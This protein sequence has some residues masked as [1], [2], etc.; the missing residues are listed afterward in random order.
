M[1]IDRKV[2]VLTAARTSLR[3][4][5]QNP[6]VMFRW[7]FIIAL[8]TFAAMAIGLFGLMIT[9]PLLG[10]ASWHAYEE[11]IVSLPACDATAN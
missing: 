5:R 2:D 8:V 6:S 3:A 7:A 1:L 11:T 4:V 10:H 9:M